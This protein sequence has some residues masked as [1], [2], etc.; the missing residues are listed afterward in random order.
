[1][2]QPVASPGMET[3]QHAATAGGQ[4]APGDPPPA[5]GN[6][7]SLGSPADGPPAAPPTPT[8]SSAFP[9]SS[10]GPPVSF[11]FVDA[12]TADAVLAFPD[13]RS[14]LCHSQASRPLWVLSAWSTVLRDLLLAASECGR[15]G[16]GR[17]RHADTVATAATAVSLDVQCPDALP[18]LRTASTA[19][20]A[21][22]A[23]CG[24]AHG[25]G[26]PR[27]E[28]VPVRLPVLGHPQEESV[29]AWGQLLELIYPP[30]RLPRP[31]VTWDNI[32]VV[33]LLADK[34]GMPGLL[35][36]CEEFLLGGPEA[37]AAAAG[38]GT[39]CGGADCAAPSTSPAA[40]RMGSNIPCYHS[41]ALHLHCHSAPHSSQQ[42]S[43]SGGAGGSG[44]AGPRCSVCSRP[45]GGG[46]GGWQQLP[47]GAAAGAG[48]AV[49][50]SD[51][52]DPAYVW[53]WLHRADRLH[54]ERVVAHCLDFIASEAVLGPGGGLAPG[55]EAEEG[56]LA[57][58]RPCTLGRLVNRLV[59]DGARLKAALRNEGM[60][61]STGSTWSA[62]AGGGGTTL[63]EHRRISSSSGSGSSC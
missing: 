21:G 61:L 53:R 10:Q 13:G 58:L 43:T 27:S 32:E 29:E 20:A 34:Y 63:T 30:S 1:M 17:G 2:S 40:S 39:C 37:A 48:G 41:S 46:G 47:H 11:P 45:A 24:G 60:R 19:A 14:V 22:A 5:A 33:I 49:F 31:A 51:P 8:A 28:E 35:L 26:H 56:L 59:G 62:V 7:H 36:M 4:T 52:G 18:H 55:G 15:H 38:T 42:G 44:S 57:E 12:S 50:S 25:C 16:R 54:M 9:Q 23:E 3:S 6:A